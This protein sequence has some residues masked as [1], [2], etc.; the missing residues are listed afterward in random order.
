MC[1]PPMAITMTNSLVACNHDIIPCTHSQ[2]R[3][4]VA[5]IV[6]MYAEREPSLSSELIL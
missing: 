4:Y 6:I 2:E 1:F 3:F 5:N